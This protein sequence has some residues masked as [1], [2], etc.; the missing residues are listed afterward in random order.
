MEKL[1]T[2][3]NVMVGYATYLVL[4]EKSKRT[5]AETVDKF[6]R[7]LQTKKNS[8][9]EEMINNWNPAPR[10]NNKKAV[11]V[12]NKQKEL[13]AKKSIADTINSKITKAKEIVNRATE[14][15]DKIEKASKAVTEE[16]TKAVESPNELTEIIKNSFADEL[17]TEYADKLI[18]EDFVVGFLDSVRKEFAEQYPEVLKKIDSINVKEFI[19]SHKD[20]DELINTLLDIAIPN[21]IIPSDLGIIDVEAHELVPIE[22][23]KGIVESVEV[24][25]GDNT[26][27]EKEDATDDDEV[28]DII[29]I[30]DNINDIKRCLQYAHLGENID[31]MYEYLCDKFRIELNAA[32]RIGKLSKSN[33][34]LVTPLSEN[35]WEL[36]SVYDAGGYSKILN[37]IRI[38]NIYDAKP[39]VNYYDRSNKL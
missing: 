16:I 2:I 22:S 17:K 13:A 5:D 10:S 14:Y 36:A 1:L 34:I 30:I 9:V 3:D 6:I 8:V 19:A 21:E 12:T 24:I 35:D 39:T 25:E 18:S 23:K 4:K 11:V 20:K 7:T 32:I 38:S 37:V 28:D 26:V 27:L 33:R 31:D 29:E 15:I